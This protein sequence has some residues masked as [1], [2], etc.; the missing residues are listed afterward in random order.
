MQ[1]KGKKVFVTGGTGGIGAVL[2]PLL[3]A[4]GAEVEVHS[5]RTH[6]DLAGDISGLRA[7][8]S[9]APPDVL[10]NLA[11]YNV[12]AYC[13]DQDAAALVH[14]NLVVPMQLSQ[15]VLPAM[16]RRGSGKIVNIGSMTGLIPLP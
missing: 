9:A 15:A 11:G 13:E 2:V 3:R 8:L 14:L 4:A 16:K 5:R 12:F 1:L 6:G 10:V 7:Q